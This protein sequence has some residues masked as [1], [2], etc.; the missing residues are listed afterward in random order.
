MKMYSL[1]VSR[2]IAWTVREGRHD[3][4]ANWLL[5]FSLA[6]RVVIER[7]GCATVAVVLGM[8]VV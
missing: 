5:I 6:G 4:W 2:W 1:I 8:V 7:V 3:T